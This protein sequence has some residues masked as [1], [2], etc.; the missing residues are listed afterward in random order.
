MADL[1]GTP[2]EVAAGLAEYAELGAARAYLRILD[3]R[4]LD[5]IALLGE[6]VV[7]G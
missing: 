3:L 1:A 2:T 5:H 7:T 6:A 4:D